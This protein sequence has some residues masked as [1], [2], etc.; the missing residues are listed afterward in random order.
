M[1]KETVE[2]DRGLT[3]TE[4]SSQKDQTQRIIKKKKGVQDNIVK[5]KRVQSAYRNSMSKI[6]SHCSLKERK[7]KI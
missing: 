6:K 1:I 2:S 7:S 3:E 4:K 5:V